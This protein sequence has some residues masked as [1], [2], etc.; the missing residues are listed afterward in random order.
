[1]VRVRY[2]LKGSGLF[3][4]QMRQQHNKKIQKRNNKL[5]KAIYYIGDE[6]WKQRRCWWGRELGLNLDWPSR[7]FWI[8]ND[9]KPSSGQVI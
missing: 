7:S 5:H 3:P 9:S 6:V 8:Q 2:F 4:S 1:M